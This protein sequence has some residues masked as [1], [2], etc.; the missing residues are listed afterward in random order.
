MMP[1][2]SQADHATYETRDKREK[3]RLE[4]DLS[5]GVEFVIIGLILTSRY[6]FAAENVNLAAAHA[7]ASDMS[8]TFFLMLTFPIALAMIELARVPP[9]IAVRV[10]NSCQNY[11][12]QALSIVKWLQD[13]GR[14]RSVFYA[15]RNIETKEKFE[16]EDFSL[17][18]DLAALRRSKYFM[19]VWISTGRN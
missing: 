12:R 18:D 13:S 2:E 17:S 7:N 10:Q 15:G 5:R 3:T 14:F 9:A 4:R 19:L 11:R 6:L 1:A 16:A 8:T